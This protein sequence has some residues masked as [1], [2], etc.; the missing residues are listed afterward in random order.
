MIESHL[1][2]VRSI[3][4]RYA[5]RGEA[6]DDLVQ[7]GA[8]GLIRASDHFD[9]ARGVAFATFAKPAIEGEIRRHL[10]DRTAPLR[11]PRELQRRTGELQRCRT[12]LVAS[13]GREPTVDELAAALDV[14]R[15]E[16][17]R[18]LEAARARDAK[19]DP[20]EVDDVAGDYEF[21][22]SSDDRLSLARG[23]QVLDERERRIVLL[24]FHA[25]MTERDIAREIGVSQAQVSRL[26]AGALAK[27][28]TELD[29]ESSV[30]AVPETE[31]NAVI[32][33]ASTE[34]PQTAVPAPRAEI[35]IPAVAARQQKADL[36]AMSASREKTGTPQEGTDV[37]LPY[38][39]AVK[40]AEGSGWSAAVEELPG[41]EARGSTAEE[42]V[43]RLRE[44]MEGWLSA[45]VADRR[46]LPPPSRRSSKRKGASAPSGRFLV[47]MPSTLHQE[48]SLAAEREQISLNRYVT[49]TLAAS[50]SAGGNLTRTE[51]AVEPAGRSARP[52]RRSFRMLLAANVTVMVF[53]AAA[54][55]ALLI[56]ALERGI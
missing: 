11:I 44:A 37:A 9:P 4:K 35:K 12:K 22:P 38:H 56:L 40:P 45:A 23:A 1:P 31:E 16:I 36:A 55:V 25:D 28:R 14:E 29:D 15:D 30:A 10:G 43:E 27:L 3:A 51:G 32:P 8:L 19:L 54:A 20:P 13:L 41:C 26:L 49:E 48:L 47:R 39:V 24:R 53:A 18:T 7:V 50:V 46:E 17:E 42:A 6:L 21:R 33:P 5:G 52:R 34:I 2:L